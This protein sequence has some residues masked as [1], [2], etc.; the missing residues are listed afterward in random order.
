MAAQK[1]VVLLGAIRIVYSVLQRTSK[2]YGRVSRKRVHSL[3]CRIPICNTLPCFVQ[4]GTS[5]YYSTLCWS[6]EYRSALRCTAILYYFVWRGTTAHYGFPVCLTPTDGR[7]A[8]IQSW[9]IEVA[10]F[11]VWYFLVEF[12]HVI[13][14][15][16]I[17]IASMKTNT[18]MC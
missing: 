12:S 4:A 17:R 18:T 10:V 13:G 6:T 2:H 11:G 1:F 7:L 5:I 9:C 16:H 14:E 3:Y 8:L 15:Q